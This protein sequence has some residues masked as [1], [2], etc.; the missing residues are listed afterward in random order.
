VAMRE[1]QRALGIG[2]RGQEHRLAVAGV[3]PPQAVA[4]VRQ[5]PSPSGRTS[6]A[7]GIKVNANE[8]V[9][10]SPSRMPSDQSLI[11]LTHGRAPAPAIPLTA[12]RG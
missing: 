8:K 7:D 6:G 9:L 5:Y 12:R 2:Q 3:E 10:A 11:W 1:L 4:S